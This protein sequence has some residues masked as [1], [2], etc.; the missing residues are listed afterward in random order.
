MDEA[1][2][3]TQ[4]RLTNGNCSWEAKKGRDLNRQTA[5]LRALD[6][7]SVIR[8]RK[9]A[10]VLVHEKK[11]IREW[12]ERELDVESVDMKVIERVALGKLIEL[13]V[14][15]ARENRL[16]RKFM[17]MLLLDKLQDGTFVEHKF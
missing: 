13:L 17:V 11:L 4:L 3:I 14:V 5:I 1:E 12:F 8:L 7:L 10:V 6:T 2:G 9:L 15:L 16:I